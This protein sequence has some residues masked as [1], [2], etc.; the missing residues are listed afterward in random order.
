MDLGGT[1]KNHVMSCYARMMRVDHSLRVDS[2][3]NASP[4]VM[5]ITCK[6]RHFFIFNDLG[7][8]ASLILP[9]ASRICGFVA[10][11]C[12]S[13]NDMLPSFPLPCLYVDGLT[14]LNCIH[15]HINFHSIGLAVNLC[16]CNNTCLI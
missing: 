9:H 15:F 4:K 8:H 10:L 2:C 11:T 14:I 12:C 13:K 6:W 1:R 7:E 16:L 5:C 3:E